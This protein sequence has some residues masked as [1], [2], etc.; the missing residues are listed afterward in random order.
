M[1]AVI[2][3]DII[4]EGI[5]IGTTV[6]AVT[7]IGA[8]IRRRS[9]RNAQIAYIRDLVVQKRA[10]AFRPA[11]QSDARYQ[12]QFDEMRNL[13]DQLAD[14]LKGG[15]SELSYGETNAVRTAFGY[16]ESGPWVLNSALERQ[17][18]SALR[19][20]EDLPWLK[21]PPGELPALS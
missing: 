8:W 13:M 18:V 3:L 7:G 19:E 6:S 11:L 4:V 1:D 9:K 16:L 14:A 15:A 12:V 17:H 20:L 21:L 5:V 10:D 2:D